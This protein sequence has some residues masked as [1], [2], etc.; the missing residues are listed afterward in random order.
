MEVL[1]LVLS[2]LLSVLSGGGIILDSLVSQNIRSQIVS[3]EQQSVRVDN[4]PS[5]QVVRGKLQKIRFA[6]RG[7]QLQP[8]LRIAALEL[9]TEAIDLD[10]GRLDVDSIGKLRQALNKPLQGAVKLLLTETDL[11]RALQSP[12]IQA[13]LQQALNRLVARKAGSTNI[14]YQLSDIHLEL[15]PSNRLGIKFKLSRPTKNRHGA[16]STTRGDRNT[17]LAIALEL[18]IRVVQGKKIQLI[19]PTGTVNQRPMSSRLLQGFAEGVSDRLDLSVLETEGIL[20]RLLQLQID[21][22]KIEL[23]GFARMETKINHTQSKE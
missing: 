18:A 8:N 5:Y 10:R 1:T 16:K 14:A 7:V 4:A 23:V 20:A 3:V 19:E 17:E 21:D 12:E 11:N 15:H 13:Q 2:G 6:T 22:D 9:E